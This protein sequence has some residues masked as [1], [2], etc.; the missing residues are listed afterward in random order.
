MKIIMAI[1]H[2]IIV[3]KSNLPL[4]SSGTKIYRKKVTIK[5]KEYSNNVV[6]LPTKNFLNSY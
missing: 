4:Y 1:K 3:K 2:S 5:N 6:L